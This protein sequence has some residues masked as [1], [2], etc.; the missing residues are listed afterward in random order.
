MSDPLGV[1]PWS[2][3][4]GIYERI[5]F[6]KNGAI[7]F[8]AET[9]TMANFVVGAI[10]SFGEEYAR[11]SPRQGARIV[12]TDIDLMMDALEVAERDGWLRLTPFTGEETVTDERREHIGCGLLIALGLDQGSPRSR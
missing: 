3:G 10:N 4:R 1:P 6:D 5:C 2:T 11:L 8:V 7:T 9:S 12:R